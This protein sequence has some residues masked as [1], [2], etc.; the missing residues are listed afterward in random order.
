[1]NLL[2]VSFRQITGF[3]K[4]HHWKAAEPYLMTA[5]I[6]LIPENPA[7][8]AIGAGTRIE[9]VPMPGCLSLSTLTGTGLF[10][11]RCAKTASR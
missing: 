10:S 2:P 11:L 4:A 6:D 3:S 9:S 5:L 1:V 7:L 8:R